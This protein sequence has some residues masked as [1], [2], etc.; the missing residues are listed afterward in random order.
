MNIKALKI[1]IFLFCIYTGNLQIE[2]R[3]QKSKHRIKRKSRITKKR[4]TKRNTFVRKKHKKSSRKK[5]QSKSQPIASVPQQ[6]TFLTTPVINQTFTNAGSPKPSIPPLTTVPMPPPIYPPIP[7]TKQKTF[8]A[9]SD[10]HGNYQNYTNMVRAIASH[11]NPIETSVL[12]NGDFCTY[13][14]GNSTFLNGTNAN[15]NQ[16]H[17][18]FLNTFTNEY[19][20]DKRLLRVF[21]LGNHEFLGGTG[22][23]A[24]SSYWRQFV[25]EFDRKRSSGQNIHMINSCCLPAFNYPEDR[26]N[27]ETYVISGNVGYV[28]WITMEIFANNKHYSSHNPKEWFR[29]EWIND[30]CILSNTLNKMRNSIDSK[31]ILSNYSVN[32]HINQN[33]IIIREFMKNMTSCIRQLEHNNPHGMLYL[34]VASHEA[35]WSI[36]PVLALIFNILTPKYYQIF[37]RLIINVIT[38][39]DHNEKSPK[40]K[41]SPYFIL[42]CN[43]KINYNYWRTKNS[44]KTIQLPQSYKFSN[45]PKINILTPG[46]CGNNGVKID[47]N[48][49]MD[50]LSII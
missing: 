44:K 26:K 16:Q 42:N 8:I 9:Y 40:Y 7:Q 13:W 46:A 10:T 37:H 20:I 23:K 34:N 41:A 3:H 19:N 35:R 39:H 18:Y 15:K 49:N 31:H 6:Q 48:D 33:N 2:A 50:N 28:S 30:G 1:L 29:Q 43:L 36:L 38:G 14:D 5:R 27:I 17:L 21:N 47:F 11:G 32:E 4:K 45:L 25:D 12:F 22:Y 24:E